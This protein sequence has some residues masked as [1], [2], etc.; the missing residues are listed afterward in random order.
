MLSRLG[1]VVAVL[2]AIVFNMVLWSAFEIRDFGT[3][4]VVGTAVS[5]VVVLSMLAVRKR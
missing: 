5:V 4:V 1:F 3:R 2:I